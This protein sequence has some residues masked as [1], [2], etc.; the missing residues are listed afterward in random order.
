MNGEKLAG[1]TMHDLRHVHGFVNTIVRTQCND[2]YCIVHHI[3]TVITF[4]WQTVRSSVCSSSSDVFEVRT[5]LR[6]LCPSVHHSHNRILPSLPSHQ[7][8][9]IFFLPFKFRQFI[10]TDSFA[11]SS[12]RGFS[13]SRIRLCVPVFFYVTFS[14]CQY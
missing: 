12:I 1:S 11:I 14:L 13:C 2:V 3:L 4:Q 7:I 8:D 9:S 10:T 5:L 6:I